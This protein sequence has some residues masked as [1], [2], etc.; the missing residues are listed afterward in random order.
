MKTL[1]QALKKLIKDLG[2]ENKVFENQI[3]NVWSIVVGKRISEISI[4]EKVE[5]KILFVKVL[6]SSWR[7]ELLYHKRNII[8]KLNKKVGKKVIDEI[9][10]F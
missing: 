10:L 3:I 2:I 8:D 5:N 6:N 1:E 7:N 9:K 4:A